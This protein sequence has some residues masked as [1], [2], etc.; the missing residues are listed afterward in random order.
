MHD[1]EDGGGALNWQLTL[2][3]RKYLALTQRSE[4]ATRLFLGYADGNN[5]NIFSFGGLNT[6][7]GFPTYSISGNRVGFA[8]L[9][10]RFPL[11]DRLDLSFM[12]L[13]AVRGRLFVDVGTAWYDIAGQEYNW[14]GEPGFQFMGEKELPDGTVRGE[15]GRLTDGVASYGFGFSITA[16]GLPMHWDF[17]KIWDFQE[18]LSDFQTEFW[19]GF[20]F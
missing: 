10:W 12:S 1:V 13:G 17:I 2:D 4:I 5:P 11:I 19:I 8:S 14:F 18:T 9:E 16:F 3:G 15:S 6:V 20:Q 7:R